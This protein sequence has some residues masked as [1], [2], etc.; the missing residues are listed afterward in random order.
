MVSMMTSAAKSVLHDQQ[1]RLEDP[2]DDFLSG[3]VSGGFPDST[4]NGLDQC[5]IDVMKILAKVL[6]GIIGE[7]GPVVSE[8]ENGNEDDLLSGMM[9][10]LDEWIRAF[11]DD[12]EQECTL[13]QTE[14]L[15]AASLSF[16]SCTGTESY[17]SEENMTFR[18]GVGVG[19]QLKEI[20]EKMQDDCLSASALLGAS[21]MSGEDSGITDAMNKCFED[22]LGKNVF[23][24]IFRDVYH[25]P[26]K[27]FTC[28][29]EFGEATPACILTAPIDNE[30]V[31]PDALSIPLSLFKKVGCLYGLAADAIAGMCDTE[32][33]GLDACL[34][35]DGDKDYDCEDIVE[36]CEDSGT[37]SVQVYPQSLLTAGELPVDCVHEAKGY[38][39]LKVLER[40]HAFH[41]KCNTEDAESFLH[42]LETPEYVP[43]SSYVQDSESNTKAY[44]KGNN[45]TSFVSVALLFAAGSVIALFIRKR[46]RGKGD[47]P[48]GLSGLKFDQMPSDDDME[49]SYAPTN[50][51]IMM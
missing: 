51:G 8:N 38:K 19:A 21:T 30:A 39:N 7:P 5:D 31:S 13:A 14:Q 35:K 44:S 40:Y 36:D 25:H 15:E 48:A 46:M 10:E 50:S 32:I 23:G 24:D 49:M 4:M 9:S 27:Y 45:S 37:F 41:I 28:V 1:R 16:L 47:F 42:V 6:P 33:E 18:V 29:A 17:F 3:L 26:Y 12:D 22:V 34:P 20:S 2:S 11:A 43:Q